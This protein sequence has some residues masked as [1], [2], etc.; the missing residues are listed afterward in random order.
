MSYP[1]SVS[2]GALLFLL[3][4]ALLSHSGRAARGGGLLLARLLEQPCCAMMSLLQAIA[5]ISAFRGSNVLISAIATGCLKRLAQLAAPKKAAVLSAS[6]GNCNSAAPA[7]L[8]ELHID[9]DNGQRTR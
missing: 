1:V 2:P 8:E 9:V 3:D 7:S 4:L 6:T 5:D